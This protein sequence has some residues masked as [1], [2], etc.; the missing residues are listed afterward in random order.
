MPRTLGSI[1][2]LTICGQQRRIKL[3][4]TSEIKAI[5]DPVIEIESQFNG[6]RYRIR[7]GDKPLKKYID[8]SE[9]AF[10]DLCREIASCDALPHYV[11]QLDLDP[12]W[13]D[14]QRF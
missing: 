12:V 14:Q 2:E 1:P 9:I 4:R 3:E 6:E 13:S 5:V 10:R 8:T 7:A 11:S